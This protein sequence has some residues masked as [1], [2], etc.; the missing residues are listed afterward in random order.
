MHGTVRYQPTAADFKLYGCMWAI[1]EI[2]YPIAKTASQSRDVSKWRDTLRFAKMS[3]CVLFM[4]I[5][6]K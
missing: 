1:G 6:G 4:L 3:D 5:F 2:M